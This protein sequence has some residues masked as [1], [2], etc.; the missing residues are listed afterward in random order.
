VRPVA[1]NVDSLN[2]SK[3][4]CHKAGY[5]FTFLSDPKAEV[6]RQYDLVHKGAGPNGRDI[7]VRQSFCWTPQVSYDG[8]DWQKIFASGSS[9]L[10]RPRGGAVCSGGGL[11]HYSRSHSC[12]RPPLSQSSAWGLKQTTSGPPNIG[13]ILS[14]QGQTAAAIA[15]FEH[16]LQLEPSGEISEHVRARLA[17]WT[18]PSGN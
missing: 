3:E 13:D 18:V 4:L 12:A 10:P 9:T 17:A 1:I 14:M 15:E 16:F 8:R 6:V 7:P 5:K 11:S 2:D